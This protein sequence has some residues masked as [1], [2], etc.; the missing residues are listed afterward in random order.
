VK[1]LKVLGLLAGALLVSGC[2]PH[3]HGRH[4]G[5]GGYRAKHVGYYPYLGYKGHHGHGHGHKHHRHR[6]WGRD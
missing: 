1:S 4:H 3:F 6:G 2:H 5:H